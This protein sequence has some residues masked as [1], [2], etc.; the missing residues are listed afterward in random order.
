MNR[1]VGQIKSGVRRQSL[2]KRKKREKRNSAIKKDKKS[3]VIITATLSTTSEENPTPNLVRPKPEGTGTPTTTT[4]TASP[5]SPTS[6]PQLDITEI[7]VHL[8]ERKLKKRRALTVR[9]PCNQEIYDTPE[10]VSNQISQSQE[11]YEESL[12]DEE[13]LPNVEDILVEDLNNPPPLI[14]QMRELIDDQDVRME[15]SELIYA[16]FS[17]EKEKFL[18]QLSE[19]LGITIKSGP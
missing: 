5:A 12:V 1:L 10:L 14:E 19:E 3:K 2:E 17:I 7:K 4:I 6:R 15:I 16:I 9:D 18:I 13:Y 11:L 8:K